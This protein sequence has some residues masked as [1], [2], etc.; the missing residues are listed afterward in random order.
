MLT[1]SQHFGS[2]LC[3]C[4]WQLFGS[5]LPLA[6][7]SRGS[8][9]KAPLPK[10]QPGIPENFS[11]VC[12][13]DFASFLKYFSIASFRSLNCFSTAFLTDPFLTFASSINVSIFQMLAIAYFSLRPSKKSQAILGSLIFTFFAL[14]YRFSFISNAELFKP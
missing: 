13:G 14:R 8:T 3:L 5:P 11:I 1:S 2:T 7:V 6:L 4:P 12:T 9:G 10:T